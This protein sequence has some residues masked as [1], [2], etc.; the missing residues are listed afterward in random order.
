VLRV[1]IHKSLRD[2][3]ARLRIVAVGQDLGGVDVLVVGAVEIELEHDAGRQ[4][5]LRVEGAGAVAGLDGRGRE[6]LVD[7]AG[8]GGGSVEALLDA[9][10]FR[11][12]L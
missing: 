8:A 7:V 1:S 4:V 6:E 2:R 11:L 10:A 12:D 5:E 9:V 3:R